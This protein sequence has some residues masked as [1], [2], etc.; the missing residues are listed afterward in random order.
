MFRLGKE[1][2]QVLENYGKTCDILFLVSHEGIIAATGIA[3]A[4]GANIN[5]PDNFSRIKEYTEE[6]VQDAISKFNLPRERVVQRL[7]ESYPD[8]LPRVGEATAVLFDFD[9][10]LAEVISPLLR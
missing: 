7:E 6:N 4:E 8:S 9:K 1:R 3:I 5:L 10:G 2:V